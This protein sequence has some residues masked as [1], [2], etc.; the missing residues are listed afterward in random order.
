MHLERRALANGAEGKKIYVSVSVTGARW[1]TTIIGFSL[2][3]LVACYCIS[4]LYAARQ[5]TD[6]R[7]WSLLSVCGGGVVVVVCGPERLA[8]AVAV[9]DD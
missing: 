5:A 8:P 7:W 1:R 6:C 4:R 9:T 3:H 2:V